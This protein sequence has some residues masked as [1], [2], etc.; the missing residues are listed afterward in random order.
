M[1]KKYWGENKMAKETKQDAERERTNLPRV[2]RARIIVPHE[3]SEIEFRYPFQKNNYGYSYTGSLIL[4]QNLEL[5]YGDHNASLV[6]SIFCL[7]LK[8][9]PEFKDFRQSLISFQRTIWAPEGLYVLNDP[10]ADTLDRF[11][12][13]DPSRLSEIRKS[14]ESG[15][16]H[17]GVIFSK[18]GKTRFAPSKTFTPINIWESSKDYNSLINQGDLIAS[19]GL[20]GVKKLAE[21]LSSNDWSF[22]HPA[23]VI[24]RDDR[25]EAFHLEMVLHSDKIIFLGV[26]SNRGSDYSGAFG[27]VKGGDE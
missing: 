1:L 13:I 20:E 6:H 27:L 16:E 17:S 21:V 19:Y 24:G 3:G 23:Q 10:K 25:S 26:G 15:V 4:E 5:P 14:I 22:S 7:G 11:G 8:N 18:D 9:E 12:S 2:K